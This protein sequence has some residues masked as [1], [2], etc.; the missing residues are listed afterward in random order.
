MRLARDVTGCDDDDDGERGDRACE[1]HVTP[2][3]YFWTR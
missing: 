2:P 3:R 1:L